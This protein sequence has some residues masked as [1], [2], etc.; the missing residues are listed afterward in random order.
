MGNIKSK[1]VKISEADVNGREAKRGRIDSVKS[2]ISEASH[3]EGFYT[4][5]R[6]SDGGDHIDDEIGD[7]ASSAST[8]E[9]LDQKWLYIVHNT[10]DYN[11]LFITIWISRVYK[12]LKSVV[13][14]NHDIST[15]VTF[16][17]FIARVTLI[18]CILQYGSFT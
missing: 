16:N 18:M 10:K 3:N 4:K 6:W 7:N 15:Y 8:V 12:R 14:F 11:Y 9:V 1:K 5:G 17:A 13:L 2:N